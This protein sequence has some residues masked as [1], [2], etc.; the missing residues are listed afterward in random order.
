MLDHES[1]LQKLTL[2]YSL[3]TISAAVLVL[4]FPRNSQQLSCWLTISSAVF[5]LPYLQDLQHSICHTA[6]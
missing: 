1:L 6:S 3:F 5:S 2:P 4:T